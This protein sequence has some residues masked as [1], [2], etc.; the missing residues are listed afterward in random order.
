[1]S[2]AAHATAEAERPGPFAWMEALDGGARAA[3]LGPQVATGTS[4]RRVVWTRN[5]TTLYRYE[6][7]VARPAAT[8]VLLVYALINKP[9]I[10]DLRPENSF[11]GHLLD[12][13]LDVYLLDWGTP[14]W[15]DRATTFDDLIGDHLPAA[16]ARMCRDS[17]AADYSLFGYCMG[18]TMATI[19]AALRPGGLRN[20]VALTTPIDFAG[21][22]T[23]SVWA[24]PRHLDPRQVA[25][26][27]GNVPADL[28]SFGSKMLRPVTNFVS[29]Q[30]TMLEKLAAGDDMTSWL[31]INKWVHDGVPFP[32]AA[33][34]QW[35]EDHY[36]RNLLI[37]GELTI[38]GE[39]V[40]LGR[41][42]SPV[43]AI[44]G[45]QDHIV[46]PRMAAP[47]LD[48]ASSADAT[49]LEL[50]AGHV[51]L[52]VGSGAQEALWPRISDWLRPRSD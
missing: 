10:L 28:V 52:L 12:S 30:T 16:V 39:R 23:F 27:F 49:W 7:R 29:A 32:G 26:G 15:G 40:D 38:A 9:Y 5:K 4:P 21:G 14:G 33:F 31:A 41:I 43:L 1:M 46:P 22:G 42:E 8:P 51:G 50:P 18:G 47:L 45:A 13:G 37:S 48:A 19:H 25:E 17:G 3:V 24:Q 6:P 2:P 34:T 44:A 11:V 20:L 36:Q 35:I